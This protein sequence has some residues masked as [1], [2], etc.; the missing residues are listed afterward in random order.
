MVQPI[1]LRL[2][3]ITSIVMECRHVDCASLFVF[4][5]R[6][7]GLS[8]ST[9]KSTGRRSMQQPQCD[10]HNHTVHP[11]LTSVSN[12]APAACFQLPRTFW[13][14]AISASRP[15]QP[16]VQYLL[17]KHIIGLTPSAA[18]GVI[19]ALARPPHLC[20]RRPLCNPRRDD[21]DAS[22]PGRQCVR[23]GPWR[24]G[25]ARLAHWR[26]RHEA[27]GPSG[28]PGPCAGRGEGG[29]GDAAGCLMLCDAG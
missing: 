29:G 28:K 1:V 2:A 23:P 20:A 21:Q 12:T 27:S 19:P 9:S 15:R 14:R 16:S 6:L 10:V 25:R 3:D 8:P 4:P 11:I 26:A 13:S 22:L 18:G 5:A 7:F 24:G 17:P